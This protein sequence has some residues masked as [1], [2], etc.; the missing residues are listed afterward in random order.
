MTNVTGGE[1]PEDGEGSALHR[2]AIQQFAS[3]LR[4]KESKE[5]MI[6]VS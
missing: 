4:Q 5:L 2:E 1:W 6:S 3:Y